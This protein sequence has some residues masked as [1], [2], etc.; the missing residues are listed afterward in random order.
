MKVFVLIIIILCM[1]SCKRDF[2]APIPDL[3]WGEF[4]SASKDPL[5]HVAMNKL[6]GVYTIME[7][8]DDFGPLAVLKW[9]YTK[10]P[11]SDT[12]YHLSIFTENE[13]SYFITEARAKDSSVLLNGYWRQLANISTGIVRLKIAAATGGQHLF[14]SDPVTTAGQVIISGVYGREQNQPTKNFKLSYLRPLNHTPSFEIIAHRGGGRNADLLPANENSVEMF[15][16]ASRFGAT[17][18]EI[19]VRLTKDGVPILYHDETLNERLI[20]KNGMVGPI[21][22]FTYQQL[23]TAV[24]LKRGGK[25]P[26]LREG[27]TALLENTPIR[28]VW[29]DLKYNGSLQIVRDIQQEFLQK[30]ANMG[31]PFEITMGIPDEDVYNNFLLLPGYQN[32]PS[33]VELDVEKVVTANA[34]IWAPMF[35]KGLQ[36]DEV[37]A[38]QAQGRRAFVWTVDGPNNV[39][40]YMYEGRFNGILSN[41]PEIVAYYYY[42]K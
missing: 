20:E 30:A 13:V 2:E 31:K 10:L 34:R 39:R 14:N 29:L 35:T 22:N 28:Y 7:G 6:E 42:A 15:M 17:G 23:S 16:L 9:S 1:T 38:I 8:G 27:L 36:N 21:K 40:K 26:T 18:V 12:V 33:L 25:I 41:Q 4:D 32:I 5:P 19:D 3:S 37:Q 24:R 11:G